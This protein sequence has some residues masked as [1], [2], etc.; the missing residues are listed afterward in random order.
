VFRPA[1]YPPLFPEGFMRMIDRLRTLAF[2]SMIATAMAFGATSVLATPASAA[3]SAR[4]EL[5]C[6][7]FSSAHYCA[8]CCRAYPNYYWDY[9]PCYCF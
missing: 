1:Q 3:D 7:N 8:A 5:Y 2:G 9:G 6:G 4:L